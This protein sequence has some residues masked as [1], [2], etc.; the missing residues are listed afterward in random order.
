M[1]DIINSIIRVSALFGR[2][3]SRANQHL[4]GLKGSADDIVGQHQSK[5]HEVQVVAS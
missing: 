1:Q 4:T 2:A 5:Q 3:S